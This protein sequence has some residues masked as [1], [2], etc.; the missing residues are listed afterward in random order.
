MKAPVE[1]LII[2]IFKK[3][4]V[5]VLEK[6]YDD[7]LDYLSG[8]DSISYVQIIIDISKK[9]EIEIQD[10]DYILYDLTT[11]NNIIRYVEDKLS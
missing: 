5:I 3:H 1:E 4:N 11:V 7:H 2:E 10:K 8:I 9:F 6:Y